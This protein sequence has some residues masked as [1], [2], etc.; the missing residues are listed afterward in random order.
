L[1]LLVAEGASLVA[2]G[3]SYLR[4]A[5]AAALSGD[6]PPSGVLGVL[7]RVQLA[8]PNAAFL[9]PEDLQPGLHHA[10][11]DDVV[12]VRHPCWPVMGTTAEP[13]IATT[14]HMANAHFSLSISPLLLLFRV[15]TARGKR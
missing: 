5:L 2:L 10:P 8:T 4:L 9:D 15:S 11:I 1:E 6:A 13:R 12:P 7:T 3:T 14:A